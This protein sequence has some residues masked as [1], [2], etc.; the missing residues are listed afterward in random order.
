CR[1][2][3][4]VNRVGAQGM[5]EGLRHSAQ[6][7]T[8]RYVDGLLPAPDAAEFERRMAEDASL[9]E[10][11][12]SLRAV[13]DSLRAYFGDWRRASPPVQI[14]LVEASAAGGA[15]PRLGGRL[16]RRQS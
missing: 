6:D 14:K 7:A 9:R 13:D 10:E 8:D 3:P 2:P 4:P 15:V 11:V 16:R 12:E 1:K 5:D